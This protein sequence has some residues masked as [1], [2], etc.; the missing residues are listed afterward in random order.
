[1]YYTIQNEKKSDYRY[2]KDEYTNRNANP[3]TFG[4]K[5]NR[6]RNAIVGKK[7]TECFSIKSIQGKCNCDDY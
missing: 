3:F 1:M 7:C 4:K 6:D 5:A 2:I